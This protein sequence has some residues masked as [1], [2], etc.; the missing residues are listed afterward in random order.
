LQISIEV[1]G[2]DDKQGEIGNVCWTIEHVESISS[3]VSNWIIV[4]KDDNSCSII[5]DKQEQWARDVTV[6]SSIKRRGM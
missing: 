3:I 4:G 6:F 1:W 2:G 5:G